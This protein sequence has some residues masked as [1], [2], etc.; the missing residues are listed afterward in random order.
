MMEDE[1]ALRS[2]MREAAG[3][4]ANNVRNARFP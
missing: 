4:R 3:P 2:A 1:A